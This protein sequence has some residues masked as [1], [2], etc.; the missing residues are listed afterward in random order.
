MITYKTVKRIS[1]EKLYHLY[2]SVSWTKGVK[3]KKKHGLL[4][5]KA[6]SNSDSVFSAW[7]KQELV[8]VIR[9]ISDNVNHAVI[10]G[11]AVNPERGDEGIAK[12]LVKRCLKKYAKMQV[13]LEAE[14]TSYKFFKSLGFKDSP[15]KALFMGECII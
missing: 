10:Y 14:K 5:S 12:E 8:G 15:N 1:P 3:D 13:N 7:D 6:Y 4:I 2:E 11:L 9:A